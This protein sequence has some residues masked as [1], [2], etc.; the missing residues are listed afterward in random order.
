MKQLV[1]P[2]MLL[3]LF[4]ACSQ[5]Q[6]QAQTQPTPQDMQKLTTLHDQLWAKKMETQALAAAGEVEKVKTA[7]DEAIQLRSQIREERTRLGL[8]ERGAGFKKGEHK[9]EGQGRKSSKTEG[10]RSKKSQSG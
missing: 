4:L 10:K 2:T 5:S 6:A 1:I 3:A 9:R 8:P 7:T